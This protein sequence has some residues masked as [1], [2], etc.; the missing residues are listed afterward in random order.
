MTHV[1]NRKPNIA[2]DINAHLSGADLQDKDRDGNP[3]AKRHCVP[4]RSYPYQSTRQIERA[5][6]K[7]KPT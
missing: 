5:K 1:N 6:R 2:Q 7:T 4:K 3:K